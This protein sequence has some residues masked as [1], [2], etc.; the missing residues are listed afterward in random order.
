MTMDTVLVEKA[1]STLPNTGLP[2]HHLRALEQHFWGS[3]VAT[4]IPAARKHKMAEA[5]LIVHSN[6]CARLTA[7]GKKHRDA[8]YAHNDALRKAVRERAMAYEDILKGYVGFNKLTGELAHKGARDPAALAAWIGRKKYGKKKF[9]RGAKAGEKMDKAI[10]IKRFSF[11]EPL[12]KADIGR[13]VPPRYFA[14]RG[15]INTKRQPGE[16]APDRVRSYQEKRDGI[17]LNRH[18]CPSCG[19]AGYQKITDVPKVKCKGCGVTKGIGVTLRRF[20]GLDE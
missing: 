3:D 5:G 6:I 11:D 7:L 19:K 13:A 12:E 14:T 1:M 9:N 4:N 18:A 2:Q 16:F 20:D 8:L 17:W 15:D 10:G